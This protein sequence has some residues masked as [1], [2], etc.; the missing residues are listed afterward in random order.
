[1]FCMSGV[2]VALGGH[3]HRFPPIHYSLAWRVRPQD[4][5]A[6]PPIVPPLYMNAGSCDWTAARCFEIP[7]LHVVST[8]KKWGTVKLQQT[9]RGT[10]TGGLS[11]A[12]FGDLQSTCSV[13]ERTVTTYGFTYVFAWFLF[14]HHWIKEYLGIIR[15][16]HLGDLFLFR[17]NLGPTRW[18]RTSHIPFWI[19][20]LSSV[21][22]ITMNRAGKWVCFFVFFL[23]LRPLVTCR[24]P[25][26]SLDPDERS[27]RWIWTAF[28]QPV[29]GA[30]RR[31]RQ[32]RATPHRSGQT[33]RFHTHVLS[34]SHGSFAPG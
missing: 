34:F 32:R 3:W 19:T 2:N 11:H 25:I 12:L 23:T 18:T 6:P 7:P 27:P 28:T 17:D 15:G 26:L 14:F 29:P 4:K 24:R 1:M 10:H 20:A 33:V 31:R 21:E 8:W 16:W 22:F 5:T 13:F 30:Q 9:E